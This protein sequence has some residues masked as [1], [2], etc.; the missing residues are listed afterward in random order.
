MVLN[1]NLFVVKQLL[2]TVRQFR[3]SSV[4]RLAYE[5][6]GRTTAT[7]INLDVG[8]RILINQC[9]PIGFKF[10]NGT[11]LMGPLI[12]FPKT[13]FCWNIASALHIN[14]KTLSLF[15]TLEP[16]PDIVVLG[17]ERPYEY[18]RI[19][20]MKKVLFDNGISVEVLPVEQ[21]CG[22]YNFLC[23]EGRYVAAGLIPPLLE[24][25]LSYKL[26]QQSMDSIRKER[27]IKRG[28]IKKQK[29]IDSK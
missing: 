28:G 8:S 21:A 15:I 20:E 18:N 3:C 12:I 5:G 13:V 17:L 27:E 14:E 16:K 24:E 10:N 4:R 2:Q 29:P 19:L 11:A 6:P 22:A 9:T 25:S 23:D 1:K 7:I 26:L